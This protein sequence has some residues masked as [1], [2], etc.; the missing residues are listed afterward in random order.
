MFSKSFGY[1]VRGILYI[2]I[3]TE[4]KTRV[5]LAEIARQLAV[6]KHFLAK[7]LKTLAKEGIIN[8]M[9]GP[10][11]GFYINQQTMTTSLFEMMKVTGEVEEFGNCVLRF[12][13]CNADNPC[14]MHLKIESLRQQW[15]QLLS[16]T[17]ISDLLKKEQPN[18]IKSIAAI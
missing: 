15:Q 1:A 17:T 13:K 9:K 3:V 2:A 11:G 18:F 4:T 12:R 5:Q 16:S 14:P 10:Y 8:S 6:P 7:V